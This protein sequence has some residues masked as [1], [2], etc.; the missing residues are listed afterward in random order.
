MVCID[1]RSSVFCR[2]HA[3]F[4]F[5]LLTNILVSDSS[6]FYK[7]IPRTVLNNLSIFFNK[8]RTGIQLD[9]LKKLYCVMC[10]LILDNF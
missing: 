5:I 7:N 1:L 10:I 6:L 4:R 3:Y 8:Y 9:A 2:M